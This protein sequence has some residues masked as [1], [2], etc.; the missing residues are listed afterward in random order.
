MSFG[1]IVKGTILPKVPLK[2]LTEEDSSSKNESGSKDVLRKAPSNL[3]DTSQSTGSSRPFIKVGGQILKAIQMMTIDETGFIPTISVTFTDNF[4][5]FGGDY[6]PKTDLILNVYIKAGS[7]KFKP[8]RSD[9]LITSITS[10]PVSA[11]D[12][13]RGVS[14]GTTYTIKGELYVPRI[15]DNVSKSYRNLN[16]K[17]ALKKVCDELGLGFAENESTPN[18]KMTW[19]NTNMS[20]LNFIQSV[21]SHAYQSDDSFFTAFIDKYYYL[22]YIEVNRQLLAEEMNETFMSYAKTI[23]GDINQTVKDSPTK[24]GLENI[25]VLNYLTTEFTQKAASNFVSSLSLLSNQGT[26]IKNHGYKKNIFYYDHLKRSDRVGDSPN[27][28]FTDFYV[29]PL[30]ST[31]RSPED[32]LI[33]N[34]TDLA[35]NKI[36]KWMNIDYG[37]AHPEWNAA[38]LINSHNLKELDKVKMKVTLN[39]IHFQNARGFTVPLYVTIRK[40]E[41]LLKSAESS[42]EANQNTRNLNDDVPDRQLSGYYYISGAKYHYDEFAKN[43]FYTELFLSRREWKP[44]K[45]IAPNA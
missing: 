27:G 38:R 29:T 4:G 12:P 7:E 9:F 21:V 33:P 34:E 18:D 15:Y 42:G 1:Q 32:Y 16:S 10:M 41:E 26:I 24:A 11:N 2:Q 25:T 19:L 35:E 6:F 39:N 3:P 23:M 30:K 17:D 28:K 45:I 31:D 14:I 20:T 43:G 5:E 22:N 44:S 40:A 36:K 37:N 8:I 13:N